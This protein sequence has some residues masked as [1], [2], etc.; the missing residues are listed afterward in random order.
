MG[1]T[2]ELLPDP[3]RMVEGLSTI[4]HHTTPIAECC[5]RL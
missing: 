4:L 5:R 2:I 3:G 1:E